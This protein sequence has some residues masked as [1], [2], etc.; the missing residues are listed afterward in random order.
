MKRVLGVCLAT[1]L[2]LSALPAQASAA[3]LATSP[4]GLSFI[5]RWEGFRGTPYTLGGETYIG[6]GTRCEPGDYPGGIT[7]EKA[8]ELLEDAVKTCEERLN[9]LLDRLGVTLEQHQYDALV[10]L[11]YTLG[12]SWMSPSS[13][14]YGCLERGLEFCSDLDIVN[15][16][17]TWCHAGG[18][19]SAHLVSR[20]L[21]EAHLFLTGDYSGENM[22]TYYFIKFDPGEG[23]MDHSVVYYPAGGAYGGLPAAV[24]EG[25]VFAGWET[26][27]G[28]LLSPADTAE[29]NLFV[30]AVWLSPGDM[31][32]DIATS[33][34]F[35]PYVTRLV[36]LRAISGF[37][38][39]T[40]RPQNP[41][42]YGQALKLILRTIGLP[43]P[44]S[45]GGHWAA[46]YVEQAR[47][48][49]VLDEN[50]AVDP[51]A[52]IRRADVARYA[53]RSL[54]QPPLEPEDTFADTTDGY[55][56]AL[57]HIGIIT[58]EVA[59][60]ARYF[61]PQNSMT[62]AEIAAVLCRML[63]SGLIL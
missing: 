59:D 54:A 21:A 26:E 6:Y 34:W 15:A 22:E 27:D 53:A 57:Y 33:D 61:R 38:D 62:R 5:M 2:L 18:Q 19:V 37:E 47:Y 8:R 58:G 48:Y 60:G 35:Y 43:E 20:R 30:T 29:E 25:W 31:L 17:G 12:Y 13:R 56:L 39:G 23:E 45:T 11:T 7:E 3:P 36:A 50:E 32:T 16:I 14:L 46:G 41:V 63:D 55:A 52:P 24:R 51:D 40:F 4:E 9:S 49:G 44:E 10:S 1:L 42:T 28:R